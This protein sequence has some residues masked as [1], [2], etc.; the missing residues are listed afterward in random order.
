MD[1]STSL[2][3]STFQLGCALPAE[4][5]LGESGRC[6]AS[7]ALVAD[8]AMVQPTG[9]DSGGCAATVARQC[10]ISTRHQVAD[11]GTH[12]GAT[13]C[14][15]LLMQSVANQGVPEGAAALILESW[16]EGTRKQYN[17]VLKKWE[18]FC[19]KEE[20]NVLQTSVDK[21]LL[22]LSELFDSGVGFSAI[23]TARSALSAILPPVDGRPVGEH[24]LV[25]RLLKGVKAKRPSLPRYKYTWD[26]SLVINH[27]RK[28]SDS[29]KDITLH[30]T[31]LLALVSGQ[32]AQ[33]LHALKVSD[34]SSSESEITLVIS[35]PLKASWD[36]TTVLT[37]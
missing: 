20:I 9:R 7:S 36:G 8:P 35:S 17:N 6:F 11:S 33:T 5:S 31:M 3:V 4:V 29:L 21:V 28:G 23:N 30:L 34:M 1:R 32:R 15:S 18:S 19:G 10:S 22:F 13:D 2:P 27:L 12:Q 16:S 26:P 24:P 14:M 25:S 37:V